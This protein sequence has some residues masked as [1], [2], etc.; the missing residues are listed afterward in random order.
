ML[1]KRA[2]PPEDRGHQQQRNHFTHDVNLNVK[3]LTP[4]PSGNAAILARIEQKLDAVLK[5]QEQ[6]MSKISEYHATV[7]ADYVQVQANLDDLSTDVKALDAKIEEL[8][9]SPGTVTPE[10]QKLLDE[11]Q[12][13]SKAL[14]EK[15]KSMAD[16]HPNAPPAPPA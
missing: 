12:A 6:I 13:D 1:R 15:T 16:T 8:Q 9:N 7:K 5:L 2:E 3:G 4:P 14:V 11:L 10:D